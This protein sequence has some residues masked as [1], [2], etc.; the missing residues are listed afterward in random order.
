MENY[1]APPMTGPNTLSKIEW[2]TLTLAATGW[3]GCGSSL[4]GLWQGS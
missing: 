1:E 3:T 2:L 4:T